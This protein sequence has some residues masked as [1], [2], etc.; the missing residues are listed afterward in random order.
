[1]GRMQRSHRTS[2]CPRPGRRSHVPSVWGGCLSHRIT[3]KGKEGLRNERVF[4]SFTFLFD[5][6]KLCSLWRIRME[7]FCSIFGAFCS[8]QLGMQ[9]TPS[10]TCM[11]SP[12]FL[13]IKG[14]RETSKFTFLGF[15]LWQGGTNQC[16]QF[17]LCATDSSACVYMQHLAGNRSAAQIFEMS[18]A[19]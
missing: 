19:L 13:G 12:A 11:D 2:G 6:C 10:A 14:F 9:V 16:Q 15:V 7:G 8:L 3:L 18:P 5:L 4:I 1:M 17:T